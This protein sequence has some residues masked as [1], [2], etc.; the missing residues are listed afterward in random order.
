M[1]KLLEADAFSSYML[2]KVR[3][4]EVEHI[5]SQAQKE[6]RFARCKRCTRKLLSSIRALMKLNFE[7]ANEKTF[8][9]LVHEARIRGFRKAAAKFQS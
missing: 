5:P 4:S 6:S 8:E 1:L 7:S 2:R 3:N 9:Q